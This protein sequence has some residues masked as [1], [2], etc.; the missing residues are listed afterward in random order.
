MSSKFKITFR[1]SFKSPE[2]AIL[3]GTWKSIIGII[4]ELESF[5]GFNAIEI[6]NIDTTAEFN[7][8]SKANEEFAVLNRGYHY[9]S[10]VLDVISSVL[11]RNGF[12]DV[13]NSID[14]SRNGELR[15]ILVGGNTYLTCTWFKMP[16]G[17]FEIVIYLS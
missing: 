1:Y 9:R 11:A 15:N 4:S 3:T 16:S 10:T 8:R 6:E 12:I 2:S 5:D 14:L 7:N 17:K 13:S